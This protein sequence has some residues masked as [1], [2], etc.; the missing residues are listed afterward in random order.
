MNILNFFL[1]IG[2]ALLTFSLLGFYALLQTNIQG[3]GIE[4][5]L[6]GKILCLFHFNAFMVDFISSFVTKQQGAFFGV[7]SPHLP[8]FLGFLAYSLKYI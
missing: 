7:A 8:L 3:H 2:G 5:A 6:I 4:A 1:N